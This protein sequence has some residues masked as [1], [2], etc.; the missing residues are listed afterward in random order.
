[1]IIPSVIS[2]MYYHHQRYK[3][4]VQWIFIVLRDKEK[5][6]VKADC[7]F[8]VISILIERYEFKYEKGP[9]VYNRLK[10]ITLNETLRTRYYENGPY[11]LI[12]IWTNK[13]WIREGSRN[14]ATIIFDIK[15]KKKFGRE[16]K[17]IFNRKLDFAKSNSLG[18]AKTK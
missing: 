8:V 12:D 16:K 6:R 17:N 13:S 15:R 1:V 7:R 14:Q 11:L 3:D 10:W 4:N 9:S 18:R 2:L 5:R